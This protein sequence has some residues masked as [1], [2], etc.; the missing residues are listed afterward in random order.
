[1][2]YSTEFGKNNFILQKTLNN[3]QSGGVFLGRIKCS[4]IIL[5]FYS[6]TGV[7]CTTYYQFRGS[8]E[9]SVQ[10]EKVKFKVCLANI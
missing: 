10:N 5:Y 4:F 3:L 1:M 2:K 6:K 7:F 9:M 8:L